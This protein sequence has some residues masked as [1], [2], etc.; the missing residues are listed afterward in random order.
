MIYLDLVT[1]TEEICNRKLHF[2]CSVNIALRWF[3]VWPPLINFSENVFFISF[4][5][6]FLKQKQMKT[7]WPR[8]DKVPKINHDDQELTYV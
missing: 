1:F 5:F 2:L 8:V 3:R 6:V 7:T 4:D